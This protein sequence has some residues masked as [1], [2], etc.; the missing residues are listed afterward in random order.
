MGQ[1]EAQTGGHATRGSRAARRRA[2]QR[3]RLSRAS[4]AALG[5]VPAQAGRVAT[6]P[7][8][9]LDP[10]SVRATQQLTVARMRSFYSKKSDWRSR[11]HEEP[12]R[13]QR[14]RGRGRKAVKGA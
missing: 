3:P 9:F 14:G 11:R 1:G 12:R 2:V 8:S 6:E 7:D 5:V 4:E 10:P 13:R